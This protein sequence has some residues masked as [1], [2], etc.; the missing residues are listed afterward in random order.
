M[1]QEMDF[2]AEY[3]DDDYRD[4]PNR[5]EHKCRGK[6]ERYGPQGQI[7]QDSKSRTH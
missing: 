3:I 5:N 7:E 6:T 4:E 2:S 1:K